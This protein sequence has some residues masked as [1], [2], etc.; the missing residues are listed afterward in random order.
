MQVPSEGCTREALAPEPH[1]KSRIENCLPDSQEVNDSG[2]RLPETAE[3]L[4]QPVAA[5]N[6]LDLVELILK[7]RPRLER[8]IRDPSLA[9]QLIPGFLA[10]SLVGVRVFGVA[11]E[12]TV[13]SIEV[14]TLAGR[15][16]A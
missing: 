12:V 7:D 6:F 14:R 4:F 2:V 3:D 11:K 8:V 16:T 9:A 5:P 15:V 13:H 10:V 1:E